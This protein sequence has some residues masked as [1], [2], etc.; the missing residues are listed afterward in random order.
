MKALEKVLTALCMFMVFGTN[1]L[2]CSEELSPKKTSGQISV[3]PD[4]TIGCESVCNATTPS[5]PVVTET[6]EFGNVTTYG[7]VKNPEPSQGGACNYGNTQIYHF[8]AI[9]V[10]LE[11]G[12]NKGPWNE[13]RICGACAKLWVATDTGF[14]Y[15]KVRIVDKCPDPFCGIDLGGLPAQEVMGQNPGRYAGQWEWTSCDD[16]SLYDGS[17]SLHVK[18]GSNQWW[19]LIQVRNGL[20]AVDKLRIRRKGSLDWKQLSWATEAENFFSVPDSILQDSAIW[21]IEANWLSGGS[22]SWSLTGQQLSLEN[23]D[24]FSE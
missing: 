24:Y 6:G 3:P 17:P 11:P 15:T 12:D 16:S 21:E 2:A 23:R 8:A 9:N 5:V 14:A 7:S 18:E 10:H 22:L 19:A 4:S 13:G 1:F 20:D